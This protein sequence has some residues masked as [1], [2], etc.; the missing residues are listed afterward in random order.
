MCESRPRTKL[1][2]ESWWWNEE[3]QE[4]VKVAFNKWQRTRTNQDRDEYGILNKSAKS[5]VAKIKKK[6]AKNSMHRRKEMVQMVETSKNKPK[7]NQ[8]N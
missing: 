2:K 7:K 6:H 1:E 8:T 4:A 3:V 5:E